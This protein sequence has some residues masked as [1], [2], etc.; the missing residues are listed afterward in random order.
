MNRSAAQFTAPGVVYRLSGDDPSSFAPTCSEAC[1]PAGLG[2]LLL[3]PYFR[4]GTLRCCAG[5]GRLGDGEDGKSTLPS[6]RTAR[7]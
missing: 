1:R 3:P 4:S 2:P 7:S 6:T 5:L